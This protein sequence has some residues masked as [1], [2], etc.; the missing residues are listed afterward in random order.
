MGFNF[1]NRHLLVLCI[2]ND[3]VETCTSSAISLTHP[4]AVVCVG[5]FQPDQGTSPELANT[6][7]AC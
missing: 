1:Y 5:C 4:E 6:T 2:L 3:K 7:V